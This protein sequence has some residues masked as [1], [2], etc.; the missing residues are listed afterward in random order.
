MNATSAWPIR[1]L[2]A[3][4]SIVASR[5]IPGPVSADLVGVLELVPVTRHDHLQDQHRL[6]WAG[7]LVLIALI[8]IAVSL[9]RYVASRGVLKGAS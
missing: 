8:V 1:L 6:A 7:A 5:Q 4:Q 2:S 9:V 3:F